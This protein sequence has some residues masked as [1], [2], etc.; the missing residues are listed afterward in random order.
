[1]R[2]STTIKHLLVIL[3]LAL[4]GIAIVCNANLVGASSV[5]GFSNDF[6]LNTNGWGGSG[7]ITRVPS[8]SA[9]I[10]AASGSYYAVVN[11]TPG[12]NTQFGG[13]SSVWANN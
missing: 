2:S 11:G 12:P 7:S 10:P 5:V 8:G 1:M 6:E 13:Y 4:T 3:S 9:G